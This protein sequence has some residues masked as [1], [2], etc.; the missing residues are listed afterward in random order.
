MQNTEQEWKD[1]IDSLKFI[2]SK[3]YTTDK[4]KILKDIILCYDQRRLITKKDNFKTY[5]AICYKLN[6]LIDIYYDNKRTRLKPMSNGFFTTNT[7]KHYDIDEQEPILNNI[8]SRYLLQQQ[9]N[10][11]LEDKN[12][13][14]TRNKI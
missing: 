7:Y 9:L 11:D 4:I 8:Y 12:Y 3:K 10:Q 13:A 2:M 1:I 6:A 5:S 14:N